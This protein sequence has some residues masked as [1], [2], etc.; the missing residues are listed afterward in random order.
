MMLGFRYL[1]RRD[2]QTLVETVP[3]WWLRTFFDLLMGKKWHAF[4]RNV[5]WIW[6]FSQASEV[7]SDPPHYGG[8][9]QWAM[10]ACQPCYR[11]GE[12]INALQYAQLSVF[13]KSLCSPISS[14]LWNTY[15]VICSHTITLLFSF[16]TIFNKLHEPSNTSL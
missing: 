5:F 16:S 6:T 15:C 2:Y 7:Q 13:F 3:K 1:T 14:H 4:N 10:A 12:T 9:Q 11:K 8:Q